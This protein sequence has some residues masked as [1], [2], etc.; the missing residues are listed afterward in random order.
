MKWGAAH[1]VS[2]VTSHRSV[3]RTELGTDMAAAALRDAGAPGRDRPAGPCPDLSDTSRC[4][5]R[6]TARA[7]GSFQG[8]PSFLLQDMSKVESVEV[9]SKRSNKNWRQQREYRFLH[10]WRNVET[11]ISSLNT[12]S[13]ASTESKDLT[14]AFRWRGWMWTCYVGSK[15]SSGKEPIRHFSL[16]TRSI[17][18]TKL[19]A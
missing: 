8:A 2:N 12:V 9:N 1:H 19:H 10:C 11:L 5:Q 6:H 18:A 13:G 4:E 3:A 14:W 16:L 17:W 7:T 15:P